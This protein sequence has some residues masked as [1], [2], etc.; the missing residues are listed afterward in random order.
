M[1]SSPGIDWLLDGKPDLSP[2][3]FEARLLREIPTDRLPV[4]EETASLC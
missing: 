1:A 3:D 2:K 4:Y